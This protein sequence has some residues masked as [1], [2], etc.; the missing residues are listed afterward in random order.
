MAGAMIPRWRESEQM[1]EAL[2]NRYRNFLLLYL[3]EDHRT[4]SLEQAESLVSG[5]LID[6]RNARV[7]RLFGKK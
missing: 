7:A 5:W 6:P 4:G 2:R 1:V 3:L